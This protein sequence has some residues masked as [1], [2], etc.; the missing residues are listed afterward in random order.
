MGVLQFREG[1]FAT[2]PGLWH[3][4][5]PPSIP[6]LGLLG[7]ASILI[8]NFYAAILRVDELI[9]PIT[10]AALTAVTL[11]GWLWIKTTLLRPSK[12]IKT[13]SLACLS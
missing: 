10:L 8:P 4:S 6:I 11:G 9:L 5:S 7:P 1:P 12:V 2:N 13:L 3:H